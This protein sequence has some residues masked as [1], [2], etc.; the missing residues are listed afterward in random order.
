L[1]GV[2]GISDIINNPGIINVDFADVKA[3]MRDT[4]DAVLGVGEGLGESK[5]AQAVELAINNALLEDTSIAGAKSLLVNVT[6]G[7]DLTIHDWNEVSQIITSQVD[8]DANIIIG[9]NEDPEILETIRVTVIATG[10]QKS[11]SN[12][13]PIP[14]AV[15]MIESKPNP[16]EQN[17]SGPLSARAYSRGQGNPYPNTPGGS[18]EE[19][20]TENSWN[21]T[22]EKSRPEEGKNRTGYSG[23]PIRNL[24][25]ESEYP[26]VGSGRSLRGNNLRGSSPQTGHGWEEDLEIPTF[27]RRNR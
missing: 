26:S 13:Q 24:P 25:P 10:F 27:I 17:V 12:T 22:D 9:L 15:G 11:G 23:R 16:R 8:A 4:G 7:S 20:V 3:I 1:N 2:R 6:G 5:V 19:Y 14:K 18:S 21:L